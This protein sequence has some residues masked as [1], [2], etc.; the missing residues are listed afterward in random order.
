LDEWELDV[1][2]MWKFLEI[3][4]L[5]SLRATR[6]ANLLERTERGVEVKHKKG[7]GGRIEG[8]GGELGE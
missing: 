7:E 6:T 5:L 3:V 1:V 2:L 8:R 4:M